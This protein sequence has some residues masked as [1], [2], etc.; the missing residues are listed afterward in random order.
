MLQPITILIVLMGLGAIFMIGRW[1]YFKF[2]LRKYPLKTLNDINSAFDGMVKIMRDL[3]KDSKNQHNI[4]IKLKEVLDTID[5]KFEDIEKR[6]DELE[7][8][9][10]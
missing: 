2:H 10:K 4:N 6:L 1:Y 7:K 5:E 8:D 3:S 9:K